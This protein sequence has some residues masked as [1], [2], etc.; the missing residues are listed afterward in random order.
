[1][2]SKSAL[3][4]IL[5][6]LILQITAC[7]IG[8]YFAALFYHRLRLDDERY[9]RIGHPVHILYG[10]GGGRSQRGVDSGALQTP[11]GQHV[12]EI[13]RILSATKRFYYRS[14]SSILLCW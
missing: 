13:N 2:R 8:A 14:G 12:V 4:N 1:M 11:G 6:N 3:K 9:D 7:D 5:A 10:A